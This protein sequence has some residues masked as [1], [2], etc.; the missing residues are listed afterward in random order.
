M[1]WIAL[2]PPHE[3][4]RR[5]WGWRA[6]KFSPRVAHAGGTLLVETSASERLFGGRR[7]LLRKLFEGM[8]QEEG[9]PEVLWARGPTSLLALAFLKLRRAGE[10]LPPEVPDGL[11]LETLEAA[12][13]HAA[14]L[15][16]TGCRTWGQLRALPRAGVARRFGA[17][18]LFALDAAYGEQPEGHTWITL[19]ESFDMKVELPALAT[20]APELMWTAQRLLSQMALWLQARHH[21]AVALEFEWTLDLKRLDGVE[22]P[23]HEQAVIRTAQP[24]QD[25]AHLRR[26]V[27]ENLERTVLRAPANHLRLRT[28]ETQPWAGASRSFLPEDNL[29]GDRL[30]HFIE[31]VSARLGA[32]N[33]IVPVPRADH[34]PERMQSW[35]PANAVPK[36]AMEEVRSDAL[37]PAWLLPEPLKLKVKDNKPQYEGPLERLVRAWRVETGWW[38]GG[39]P[40][41]RDYYIARSEGAGLVWIYREL[42]S[43]A[44]AEELRE[45]RWYLQGLYA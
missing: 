18:L 10:A 20:T 14:T 8:G 3:E 19:P 43:G 25:M 1:H 38:E 7:A 2:L 27:S 12:L 26:L 24:T 11:P 44:Q 15:E 5:A 40:A 39:E 35:R 42:T 33:V 34:R 29:K 31:R 41:L 36:R 22:L 32:H 28:L 9:L 23:A 13:P 4:A 16:R 37:Y 6:L 30:H 45:H 21:G 17:G